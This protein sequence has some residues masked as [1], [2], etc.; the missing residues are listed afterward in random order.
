MVTFLKH[1]WR[2]LQKI[3]K[4]GIRVGFVETGIVF[5]LQRPVS[6]PGGGNK[7][8]KLGTFDTFLHVE[9]LPQFSWVAVWTGLELDV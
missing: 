4:L 8:S 9:L 5:K 3:L 6:N 2:P 7:A 1:F